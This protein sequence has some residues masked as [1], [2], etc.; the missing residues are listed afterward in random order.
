MKSINDCIDSA[1]A[2]GFIDKDR[3]DEL[4]ARYAKLEKVAG[5]KA[6]AKDQLAK[7]LSAEAFHKNYAAAKQMM[8]NKA[9][10]ADLDRWRNHKNEADLAEALMQ[11][12]E[13]DA[14]SGSFMPDQKAKEGA[15]LRDVMREMDV[16]VR[17][18]RKGW[19]SGDLR[20]RS[21]S[22]RMRA[23]KVVDA[24][25]GKTTDD[26][27]ANEFAAKID[28]VR[29]DLRVRFN[30]G[31]GVIGKLDRYG[32]PMSWDQEAL[33]NFIDMHGEQALVDTIIKEL[34]RDRMKH[35][36]TGRPM[37]DDEIAEGTGIAIKRIMT[38]GLIDQEPTGQPQGKGALWKQHADHRFF[39][40]KDGA[41]W[42][43][44]ADQFGNPDVYASVMSH[45]ALMA[46]D[47]AFIERFGPNAA[48]GFEYAAQKVRQ[49]AATMPA[50]RAIYRS[51]AAELKEL[52]AKLTSPNPDY[53]VL[54]DKLADL[55]EQLTRLRMTYKPQ[56]GGKP[57]AKIKAR[58]EALNAEMA[59]TIFKLR[60]Y[61]RGEEPMTV[62]DAEIAKQMR[63][64][65]DKMGDD[66]TFARAT[67]PIAYAEHMIR[68][69]RQVFDM[70]RGA[71]A[72]NP[73]NFARAMATA[74]NLV[75]A[76]ALGSAMISAVTDPA[77]GKIT[78]LMAGM[79]RAERSSLRILATTLREAL[80]DNR[81]DAIR[82]GLGMDQAISH[83][84]QDARFTGLVQGG[85]ISR[86]FRQGFEKGSMD[87]AISGVLSAMEGGSAFLADRIISL[88]GLGAWTQGG[89]NG[90][91]KD[92]MAHFAGMTG[93]GW[94]DLE[95]RAR[96][97]MARHGFTETSWN[98]I[99][100]A[101]PEDGFW[102]TANAVTKAGGRAL[103]EQWAMMLIKET[104]T[105]I[106]EGT[107]R[108]T[109]AWRGD[110]ARGTIPG[111]LLR[112]FG[113]FKSFG[114]GVIFQVLRPVLQELGV[115]R[116]RGAEYAMALLVTSALLGAVALALKDIKDGRDPRKVLDD[117]ML[118]D[119]NFW[120]A[121]I[122]QGGGFGIYGDFL[123][124]DFNRF[125]G[126]LPATVAG[127]V[128]QRVDNLA[129]LTVGNLAQA[130]KGENTNFGAEA[131]R[132]A[133]LN[134]PKLWYIQK[135]HDAG[136]DFLQRM[137]DPKAEQA[138]A[139]QRS[140]RAKDYDGQEFWWGPGEYKPSRPPNLLAPFRTN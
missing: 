3:A 12:V 103:G 114:F 37:S 128:W 108:T 19:F 100:G 105:A 38:D 5:D 18:F 102:L 77:F 43:R 113:Q 104:R 83:F 109:T 41:A 13:A 140:T 87:G 34:D 97:T 121:A 136:F 91:A 112:S 64:V 39:H 11:M 125:G 29:D 119:P 30:E 78:R 42:R 86:P 94:S 21:K 90:I 33:A 4:K 92:L 88:Q 2:Q 25:F 7:E 76:N 45:F 129:K 65:I 98:T 47:I 117:E 44:I 67:N 120:V 48:M 81:F 31:G 8:A 84:H 106:I 63:D 107:S 70:N 54:A 74:R 16:F 22:V 36:L 23:D 132:F 99:R 111:E 110:A 96:E 71:Q 126:S 62:V 134:T 15:I 58:I 49:A 123:F 28:K 69:A 73:N 35:P 135:F 68:R 115:N 139:K 80:P 60:P 130:R 9:I 124:A 131:V 55:H 118:A 20:R 56:L 138:F 40:F 75:T 1:L 57:T 89:K 122:A 101:V 52:S 24:L 66:V 14:R 93:K 137:F 82:L 59:D 72:G 6:K 127:P 133:R 32:M 27:M 50:Q 53:S 10:D 79:G 95:P 85:L 17:E 61:Y 26:K 51:Y 46:R 116:A